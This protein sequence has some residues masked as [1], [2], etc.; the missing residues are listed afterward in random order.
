MV[1]RRRLRLNTAAVGNLAARVESG[2]VTDRQRAELAQLVLCCAAAVEAALE[3]G[4]AADP[5]DVVT[6]WEPAEWQLRDLLRAGS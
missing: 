3:L 2:E 1:T 6:A 5:A 4:K